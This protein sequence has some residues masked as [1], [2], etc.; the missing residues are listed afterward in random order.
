MYV[1]PGCRSFFKTGSTGRKI[2][3]LRCKNDY[4]ADLKITDEEWRKLDPDA[5]KSRINRAIAGEQLREAIPKPVEPAR[6]VSAEESTKERSDESAIKADLPDEAIL[7]AQKLLEEQDLQAEM[8]R[9]PVDKKKFTM[10]CTI[11]AGLIILLS[12]FS[13]VFPVFRMREEAGVLEEAQ[14]GDMV[15]YGKYKG[16]TEWTVLERNDNE[17]LLVSNYAVASALPESERDRQK[18]TEWLNSA[19]LNRSFNIYERSRLLADEDTGDSMHFMTDSEW[20]QYSDLVNGINDGKA[21]PVC[22]ISLS[23]NTL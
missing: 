11:T 19:F 8:P 4:L 18:Q 13:L 6:P 7:E 23:D 10:V 5:R 20:T 12:F 1:C 21:H 16:N 15:S 9:Q 14:A 2:K 22:R 17:F 3:C